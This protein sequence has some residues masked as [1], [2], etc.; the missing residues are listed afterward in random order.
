MRELQ[1]PS[2]RPAPRLGR[3]HGSLLRRAGQTEETPA[4]ALGQRVSRKRWRAQEKTQAGNLAGAIS[5]SGVDPT[6]REYE[7]QEALRSANADRRGDCSGT[8]VP[9]GRSLNQR[10]HRLVPG[11]TDGSAAGEGVAGRSIFAER[12]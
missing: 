10:G 2:G 12:S 11:E 7:F 4:V 3:S 6:L 1:T 9:A 8:V 5:E